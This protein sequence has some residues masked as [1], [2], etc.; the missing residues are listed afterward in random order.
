MLFDSLDKS[1][2]KGKYTSLDEARKTAMK[3]K[4]PVTYVCI[5]QTDGSAEAVGKVINDDSHGYPIYSAG[6]YEYL[7][8]QN[9]SLGKML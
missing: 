8:N 1:P 9:G 5:I 6:G 2:L 4:R 7:L 3:R